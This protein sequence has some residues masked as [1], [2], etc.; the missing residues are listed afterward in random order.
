MSITLEQLDQFRKF[1]EQRLRAGSA[2]L[3]LVDLAAEWQFRHESND[4]LKQDGLAVKAALRDME[5]GETGRPMSEFLQEFEQ[6][7]QV[8]QES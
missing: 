2:D 7:H 4:Y 5:A 8:D 6:R 3:N 1:A